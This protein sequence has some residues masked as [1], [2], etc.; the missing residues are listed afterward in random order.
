MN[1]G[2]GVFRVVDVTFINMCVTFTN[3]FNLVLFSNDN[4]TLVQSTLA[5]WEPCRQKRHNVIT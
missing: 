1:L 5:V 3:M 2:P 4:K